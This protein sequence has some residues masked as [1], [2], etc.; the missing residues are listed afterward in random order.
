[1][2]K[3]IEGV[4]LCLAVIL[5]AFQIA[6]AAEKKGEALFKKHCVAC[7]VNGGN[8]I[9]PKKTLHKTDR[10]SNGI[11]TA[12]DIVK[13]MRNP[14]PGMTKFDEQTIPSKDAQI[15]AEYVFNTFK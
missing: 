7:H 3:K 5:L 13:L 4:L 12:Q 2:I 6:S 10:E 9:N 11:K 1:M 14:G 8:I 15:I